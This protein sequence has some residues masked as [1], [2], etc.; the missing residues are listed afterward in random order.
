LLCWYKSA[1][2]DTW[3]A[4][5]QETA[6]RYY[7]IR[8]GVFFRQL[9]DGASVENLPPVPSILPVLP[10]DIFYPFA[11]GAGVSSMHAGFGVTT[12]YLALVAASIS[13]VLSLR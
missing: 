10:D 1:N 6:E 4:A 11:T 3:G 2:T 5:W 9:P 12:P 8:I 13:L 7:S